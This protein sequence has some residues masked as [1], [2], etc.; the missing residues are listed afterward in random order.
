M[1]NVGIVSLKGVD[2]GE[3]LLLG[4]QLGKEIRNA[5]W[6]CTLFLVKRVASS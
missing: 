6:I 3:A 5:N 1:S 4:F 2:V